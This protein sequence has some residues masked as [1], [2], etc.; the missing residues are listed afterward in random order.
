MPTTRR[1]FVLLVTLFSLSAFSSDVLVSE[2]HAVSKS[3]AKTTAAKKA[4][5]KKAAAKKAAAKKAAAKKAAAKRKKKKRGKKPRYTFAIPTPK[6]P[7]TQS[8]GVASH[9]RLHN[10][11]Q[12]PLDGKTFRVRKSNQARHTHYGNQSL[13]DVLQYAADKTAEK[14]PMAVLYTGDVSA[15]KGGQLTSHKS[16]QSGLD[17]DLSIYMRDAEGN[18]K[19]DGAFFKLNA[20]GKTYDGKYTLD[21]DLCWTFVEALLTSLHAQIQYLFIYNP[22]K[23]LIL[24]AGRRAGADPKIIERAS[25]VMQQPGDSSPHADHFHIRIYC[26]AKDL[27]DGCMVSSIIWPWVENIKPTGL[28]Q[29]ATY[30]SGKGALVWS[31]D[32]GDMSECYDGEKDALAPGEP[33]DGDYICVDPDAYEEIL[34]PIEDAEDE[35]ESEDAP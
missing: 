28:A 22:L 27:T 14:D 26:P 23:H 25:F 17:A 35:E 7:G 19:L 6:D 3:A 1:L 2:A 30:A 12:V 11:S 32:G 16:H 9:G 33:Q 8:V 34:A 18:L 13:I 21:A 24:E 4:A 15:P 20:S 31:V 5:A 29:V 10:P